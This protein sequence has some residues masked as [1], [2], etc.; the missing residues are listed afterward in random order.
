VISLDRLNL[1]GRLAFLEHMER[2]RRPGS[3]GSVGV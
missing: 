1:I 3:S 2:E